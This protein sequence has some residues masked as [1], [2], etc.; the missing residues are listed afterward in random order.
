MANFRGDKMHNVLFFACVF[1]VI[2]K[3]EMTRALETNRS[4][5][6]TGF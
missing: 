6:E 2:Q 4:V 5:K 1:I 3:P